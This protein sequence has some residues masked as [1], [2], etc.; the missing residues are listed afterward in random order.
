MKAAS[1]DSAS[2]PE[3][4]IQLKGV[5]VEEIDYRIS[6][7]LDKGMIRNLT[8]KSAWVA[9]Y[10]HVFVLGPT[11]VGKSFENAARRAAR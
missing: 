6:R 9:Q 4:Q 8:Q 10:E 7:G 3:T 2:R 11:G 5:C 1:S